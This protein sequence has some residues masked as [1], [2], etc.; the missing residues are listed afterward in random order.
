MERIKRQILKMQLHN[1]NNQLSKL[2]HNKKT[3]RKQ[4]LQA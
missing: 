3:L 4:T 2:L 1:L